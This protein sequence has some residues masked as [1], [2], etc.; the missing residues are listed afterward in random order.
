MVFRP[1]NTSKNEIC[2][3][4]QQCKQPFDCPVFVWKSQYYTDV[5]VRRMC[6]ARIHACKLHVCEWLFLE[7][8]IYS[9]QK[10]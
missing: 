8:R 6:I 3:K 5:H 10:T 4:H 2:Q 1:G 7:H 9:Q